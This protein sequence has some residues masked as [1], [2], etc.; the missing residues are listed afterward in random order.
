MYAIIYQLPTQKD[1]MVTAGA[2]NVSLR[3]ETLE[4]SG[5]KVYFSNELDDFSSM[6]ITPIIRR[7]GVIQESE[8]PKILGNLQA[9]GERRWQE[10]RF[11]IYLRNMGF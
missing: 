5:A 9:L 10:G 11:M 8:L 2:G 3:K 4:A 1:L 7:G 6:I